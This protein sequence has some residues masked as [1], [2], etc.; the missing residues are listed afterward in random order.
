M[1]NYSQQYFG[2]DI[3]NLKYDDINTLI[4]FSGTFRDGLDYTETQMTGFSEKEL[5]EKFDSDQY[6]VQH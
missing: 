4:A 3:R 6:Q 1:I 5:P 2:K